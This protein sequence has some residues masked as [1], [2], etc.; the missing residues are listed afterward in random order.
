[1][2][3]EFDELAA[4]VAGMLV[5][6]LAGDSGEDAK[7]WFAAVIGHEG[8]LAAARAELASAGDGPA[9]DLAVQAQVRAW[10]IRLRDVFEDNPAAAQTLQDL[11]AGMRAQGLL[12]PP[13][14]SSQQ[15]DP[16][17]APQSAAPSATAPQSVPVASGAS[18]STPRETGLVSAPASEPSVA[19]AQSRQEPPGPPAA[20]L[21]QTS[22]PARLTAPSTGSKRHRLSRSFGA[23]AAVDGPSRGK[24]TGLIAAGIAV[25]VALAVIVSWQAG[26]FGGASPQLR[27]LGWTDT[28]VP[29]PGYAAA[30][31][32]DTAYDALYGVSC[33]ATGTC[34]AVGELTPQGGSGPRPL[35]ERLANGTWTPEQTQPPLPPGTDSTQSSWLNYI[36]CSSPSACTAVG[37][38]STDAASASNANTG[39]VETLSG[40]TWIPASVPLPPGAG[41]DNQVTLVSLACP[42]AGGCIAVGSNRDLGSD[43]SLVGGRPLIATQN[44]GTWTSAEAPLPP[45]AATTA[46]QAELEF[47]A[48][49]GPGT[50]AA[51]GQYSD[52][53]GKQQGLIDILAN[54]TWTAAKAPLPKNAAAKPAAELLGVSCASGTCVAVGDFQAGS[55]RTK[56]EALI[57]T[58]PNGNAT[59][60]TAQSLLPGNESG[61]DAV[62][63]VSASSCLALGGYGSDSLQSGL[64][65]TLTDGTWSTTSVPL[66]ANAT[67]SAQ[68]QDVMLWD[69]ACPTTANCE[70]V[71]NYTADTGAT[72][73][74]AAT[75][76]VV[77]A[78]SA[79]SGGAQPGAAGL[80][81]G[82]G[83]FQIR[84]TVTEF[85]PSRQSIAL[86]GTVDGLALTATGTGSG[87]AGGGFAGQDGYCGSLGLVGSSASGTLGGV[88]FTVTLTG[89]T[90]D[91]NGT[92]SV[93]YT[94]TWGSRPVKLTLT[95]DENGGSP[96]T[97]GGTV[98][99][100]QVSG[101]VPDIVPAS[102]APGQTS[103]I[104]GTITVS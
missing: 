41:Q 67:T 7:Q 8:R 20:A 24:A 56:K 103:Q 92:L 10:T 12:K 31:T 45:D 48:C 93:T 61:L 95:T 104:S 26:L 46:Q 84:G 87:L 33:P 37:A 19:A 35:V 96:P 23:A 21:P 51:V 100:Q 69:V 43:G 99:A 52:K 1:M 71:G 13:A 91:S 58:L 70:A 76:T 85:D 62:Y 4:T 36:V 11:V 54:G 38:Y 34:L 42:A 16:A 82:Q 75:G 6:A 90:A 14:A 44:G 49:T 22:V 64:A 50:C 94:G 101:T 79:S 59:S 72:V 30:P 47:T 63:C 74:L 28:Q 53:S 9:H 73:P 81:L 78:A 3:G 60:A 97:L 39:L 86:Q 32:S 98:G 17:T 55:G 25:V 65:A 27:P 18:T 77:A 102:G 5:S 15:A 2:S 88:L 89:C 57:E 40:T 83:T 66:P 68:N 80:P 29:L